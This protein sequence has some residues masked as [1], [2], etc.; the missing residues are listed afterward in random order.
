MC[1]LCKLTKHHVHRR[2]ASLR[3]K[4]CCDSRPEVAD[5]LQK[6][7]HCVRFN[8]NVTYRIL[9]LNDKWFPQKLFPH[10]KQ[11]VNFT[12]NTFQMSTSALLTIR[13]KMALLV[14]IKLATT[15]VFVS[16][17][18]KEKIVIKV[19]YFSVQQKPIITV[20]RGVWHPLTAINHLS[21][22][23]HF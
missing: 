9:W 4:N 10:L 7:F 2:R 5:T 23:S 12:F 18:I 6:I 19:S 11:K 22:A 15:S 20:T 16:Q 1:H 13:V 17:D 14:L 21:V 3:V 8:L